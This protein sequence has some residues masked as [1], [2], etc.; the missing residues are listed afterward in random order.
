MRVQSSV[1]LFWLGVFARVTALTLL[2]MTS[3]PAK[4]DPRPNI[5]LILT[6]DLD[7]RLVRPDVEL[8]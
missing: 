1:R 3:T 2:V 4:A 6:D 7:W 8:D 5:V